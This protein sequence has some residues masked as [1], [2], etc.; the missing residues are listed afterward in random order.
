MKKLIALLLLLSLAS[1]INI[2]IHSPV[3]TTTYEGEFEIRVELTANNSFVSN[4]TVTATING[5]TFDV[6][7]GQNY[8]RTNVELDPGEKTLTI[9][10]SKNNTESIESMDF[11]VR[12][13]IGEGNETEYVPGPLPLFIE[14]ISPSVAKYPRG[15][16][17]LIS[18][19]VLDIKNA[20]LA[21]V[22]VNAFIKT[23]T[24]NTTIGLTYISEINPRYEAEFVLTE[25]G[26]HEVQI[27]AQKN[28]YEEATEFYAPIKVGE[29]PEQ[30]GEG[31]ECFNFVCLRIVSPVDELTVDLN[32]TIELEVQVLEEIGATPIN[33]ALVSVL[34]DGQLLTMTYQNNGLYT[35]LAGPLSQGE[36][37]IKYTAEKNNRSVSA[38][39]VLIVSPNR[40]VI[41]P[42]YP[43]SGT[44]ITEQAVLVKVRVVDQ[45][46]EIVSGANIRGVIEGPTGSHTVELTRNATTGIYESFYTFAE[47]GTYDLKFVGSKRGFVTGTSQISFEISFEEEGINV[48]DQTIA[49]IA[50]ILGIIIVFFALIAIF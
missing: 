30:A 50:I 10:A 32:S 27:T 8:Y 21:N 9:R 43:L 18:V 42:I 5:Q 2:T 14:K 12:G 23:P 37:E 24:Q 16:T 38:T 4:A 44:N 48:T 25:D 6:P 15:E 46:G 3:N 7:E 26:F 33:D 47:L 19:H 13:F 35:I 36:Y 45:L 39:S 28:G 17:L 29:D 22:T 34:V 20:K 40:I 31:F 41:T 49:T 1:G 11:I